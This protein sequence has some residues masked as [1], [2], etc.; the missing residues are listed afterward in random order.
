M[1][2][3]QLTVAPAEAS[4]ISSDYYDLFLSFVGY[5]TRSRYVSE[6]FS[7][8]GA[9]L[10]ACGFSDRHVLSF[11]ENC[12]CLVAAGY[13][14]SEPND[15]L[16]EE[17]VKALL[18]ECISEKTT[19]RIGIDI[20]SVSRLRLAITLLGLVEL[21]KQVPLEAV[22][23][24]AV[25]AFSEPQWEPEPM[26]SAGPVVP[27]LAGWAPQA[28]LPTLAIVGLGY[29]PDKAVGALEY[30]EAADAWAFFPV[31]GDPRYEEWVMKANK[32]LIH[33]MPEH[34]LIKYR[35][36]QPLATFTLLESAVS[37]AKQLGRVVVVPFGPKIFALSATIV[38]LMYRDVAVWRVSSEQFGA[39][40][41]RHA[42]G[43]V[44]GLRVGF[45]MPLSSAR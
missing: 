4:T 15:T 45:G 25:G 22:F 32:Y 30:L 6:T 44:V 7:P 3:E 38:G 13:T 11:E 27:A 31:G 35:V 5:E 37:G 8:A 19:L 28:Q 2:A 40:A 43:E 24:Y 1:L 41:D 29:E 33:E 18:R 17:W 14:Y 34:R 20:S 16:F 26:I 10:S 23:W 9:R 39:P 12:R 21:S 42:S 36:D